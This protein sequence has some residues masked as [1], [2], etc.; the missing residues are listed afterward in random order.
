MASPD[1]PQATNG[2]ERNRDHEGHRRSHRRAG[3]GRTDV[4]QQAR[5]LVASWDGCP[6]RFLIRDRDRKY[7][8]GFDEVFRSEGIRIVRTP[9]KAPLANAFAERF[10][11]TLRRE[12]LDRILVFGRRH[13]E[14]R[15]QDLYRSL[16]RSPTPSIS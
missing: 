7:A 6:F 14:V 15:P 11:G 5:N 4:T 8:A 9:I 1:S 3:G 12:C 13:L 16:Q 2:R 10:V